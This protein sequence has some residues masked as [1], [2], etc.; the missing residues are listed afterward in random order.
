[1]NTK[2]QLWIGITTLT[3]SAVGINIDG[4][5]SLPSVRFDAHRPAEGFYR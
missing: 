4:F 2:M 5:L 1:M 3:T